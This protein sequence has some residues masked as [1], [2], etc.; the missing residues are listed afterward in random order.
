MGCCSIIPEATVAPAMPPKPTGA[1]NSTSY[2]RHG[3]AVREDIDLEYLTKR[4]PAQFERDFESL[5]KKLTEK[6]L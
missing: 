2:H 4:V 1:N 6:N 3:G 5:I